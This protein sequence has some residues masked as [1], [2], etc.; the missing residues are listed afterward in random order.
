MNAV[1][2]NE[3]IK[4]E[5][6]SNGAELTSIKL[7]SD[8]TQYLWQASSEHWARHAP[9][10]F[11]I[12]GRVKD[13]I[14]KISENVYNMTQHGFAR[15]MNFEIIK[16]SA[17]TVS[18][19]LDWNKGTLEKYPYKFKLYVM[20]TLEENKITI[21]YMVKNIDTCEIYFSIGAHPAFNC[22]LLSEE[23]MEDYYI[24]F[25]K[26]EKL[27]RKFLE[28]GLVSKRTES[29]LDNDNKVCLTKDLLKDDVIIIEKFKSSYVSLKSKKSNKMITLGVKGFPYMGIWSKSEQSPFICIEP[30]FGYNDDANVCYD[31]SKKRGIQKLEVGQEFKCDFTIDIK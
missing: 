24:E 10:L 18:Y 5:T 15:D 2:E 17:N 26:K 3:F 23:K 13:D 12:V 1:L 20:Y 9:I 22:P 16:K 25:D 28:D 31:F 27:D 29:F 19:V 11:P 21:E 6:T 4:V 30:L 14:I 8:D 7:K